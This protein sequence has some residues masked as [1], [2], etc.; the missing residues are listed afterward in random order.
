MIRRKGRGIAES[1][2]ACHCCGWLRGEIRISHRGRRGRR[3]GSETDHTLGIHCA[4]DGVDVDRIGDGKKLGGVD[5]NG[6]LRLNDLGL[7][8]LLLLLLRCDRRRPLIGRSVVH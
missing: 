4:R 1:V 7:L 8:L 2:Q 3:S 6:V 5:V